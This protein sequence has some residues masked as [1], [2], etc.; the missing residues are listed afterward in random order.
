MAKEKSETHENILKAAR[1]EFMKNGFE[2][3]SIREIAQLAKTHG[4]LVF[5]ASGIVFVLLRRC[6]RGSRFARL[7]AGIFCRQNTRFAP[8]T[9]PKPNCG[10]SASA[11]ISVVI[12]KITA[13]KSQTTQ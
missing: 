2:K 7:A 1:T 9:I 12:R 8:T 6:R 4:I 13:R 10:I 3:T 5:G 11:G